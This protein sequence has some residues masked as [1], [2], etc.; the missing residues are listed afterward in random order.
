MPGHIRNR[1]RRRSSLGT[2]VSFSPIRGHRKTFG[3]VSSL[4]FP[5][6]QENADSSRNQCRPRGSSLPQAH[7]AGPWAAPLAPPE[8]ALTSAMSTWWTFL[9]SIPAESTMQEDLDHFC[10]VFLWVPLIG[11]CLLLLQ[12]LANII[13]LRRRTTHH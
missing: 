11:L 7:Q 3:H 1:G 9:F 2:Q 5:F 8:V 4:Q 13:V 10:L 12:L 6:S